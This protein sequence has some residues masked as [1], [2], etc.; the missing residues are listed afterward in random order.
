MF[1][2]GNY[3]IIPDPDD[4]LSRNILKICYKYAEKYKYEIIRFNRYIG[5]NKVVFSNKIYKKLLYQPELST[6]MFYE[7]NDF[8]IV[9]FWITNKLIKRGTFIKALNSLN[10][11]YLNL[12]I[13]YSE[14]IMINFILYRIAHS[15][16]KI[17]NVGYYHIKNSISLSNTLFESAKLKIKFS[18]IL[19]KFIFDYSK[20]TKNEKDMSQIFKSIKE[21]SNIK[22]KLSIIKSDF[23]F[24][25][26]FINTFIRSKF[27]SI[28]NK[29]IFESF[30][31]FI[32]FSFY[33][34]TT[35]FK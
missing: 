13:T 7:I 34:N 11:Y 22:D 24:Y 23:N 26:I 10:N 2:K 9:D 21:F 35:N 6:H 33:Y 27:I 29:R 19:L 12:Y 32:D 31:N 5:N 15:F 17:Q 14:D 4:I 18:F 20:N 3:V 1:S 30:K 16:C 8:K 25:K 28:E